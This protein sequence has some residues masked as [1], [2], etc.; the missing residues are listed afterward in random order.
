MQKFILVF[1][2]F[3]LATACSEEPVCNDSEFYPDKILKQKVCVSAASG[4]TLFIENYHPNGTIRTTGS[5]ESRVRDGEWQSFYEN[6]NPWSEHHY[7]NGKKDGLY[8]VWYENGQLR[9]LGQYQAGKEI[10]N[11][12]FFDEN[13]NLSK[14]QLMN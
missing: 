10:G 12:Q 13:G 2:L 4:D 8:K 5:F 6:G 11:W 14:E 9:I 7:V 3:C 1:C